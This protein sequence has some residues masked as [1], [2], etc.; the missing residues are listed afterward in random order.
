MH[1]LDRLWD[2]TD[3]RKVLKDISTPLYYATLLSLE[4]IVKLLLD[5]GAEPN[6]QGGYYGNAL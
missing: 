5:K 6:A 3:F 2:N 4:E 1:D